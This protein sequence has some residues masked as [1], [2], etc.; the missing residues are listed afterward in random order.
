M[1]EDLE[2]AVPVASALA[3]G[4]LPV[5]EVTFR[6]AVAAAAIARIAGET[7]VLVGAGTVVR[8]EQVDEAVDGGRAIHRHP[9]PQPAR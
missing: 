9:G 1:L 3:E 4:G 5:A 7:D 6:T 8:P 2:T